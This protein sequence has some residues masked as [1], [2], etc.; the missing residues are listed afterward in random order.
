MLESLPNKDPCD[1]L[2]AD[3]AGC[4]RNGK[5]EIPFISAVF[6]FYTPLF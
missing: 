1:K 3:V 5:P 2:N 4:C 6:Y